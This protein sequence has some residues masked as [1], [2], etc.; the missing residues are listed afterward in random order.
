MYICE[1]LFSEIDNLEEK[2]INF[3]ENICSIESPTN[4]KEGLDEVGLYI[5]DNALKL[6]LEVEIIKQENAGNIVKVT[7]NNN[8]DEKPIMI[9]AHIDTVHPVGSFGN[10]PVKIKDGIIYGPG[11]A[12]DKGGATA[13][14]YAMHGLKNSGYNKRNVVFIAQTD[15]EVSSVLS[16]HKTINYICNEAK[17]CEAFINCESFHKGEA[18]LRRKGIARYR[19]YIEGKIAHSARCYS[20]SSALLE[21]SHK[22]IDIEKFKDK[23]GITCNCSLIKA[24]E[25]ANSV[26]DK[27]E[28]TVDVRYLSSEQYEYIEKVL[29][30]IALKSYIGNTECKIVCQSKRPA[31]E[32]ND[33]NL[34]FLDKINK[35]YKSNGMTELKVGTSFGG[36]DAA[37][38]SAFGVTT[39]DS[40]GCEGGKIHSIDEFAYVCSLKESAKRISSIIYCYDEIG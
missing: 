29:K 10:P 15:E 24:G 11:V 22:I 33:K 28:F 25:V 23:E 14:L 34:A 36:S 18:I 5:A 6:G 37:N 12:D 3:W 19:F 30:E 39:I 9:S 31:M 38:V 26:P 2:Y 17:K 20:G 35:I 27:C 21:A 4:Y 13:A 8:S 40:I 7:L 1:K 32:L 16:N